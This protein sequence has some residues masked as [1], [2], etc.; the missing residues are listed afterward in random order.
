MATFG[1]VKNKVLV[2]LTE[3]YGK[4]DFSDNLKKYFKPIM[5]STVLKEMYSLYEELE[6]MTFN[7]KE[8][9]QIYV[10]ELSKVL[11]EKH[12]DI[13][14][15]IF[16]LN[17]SLKGVEKTDNNLYEWL[18]TLSSPDKLGN[19]SDKVVAKKN[20]VEHLTRVKISDEL[21][22]NQGVNE[23][24]LNSV[25]VNNFNVSYD[26]TL[27]E[28][29]KTKLKSILSLNPTD[30]SERTKLVYSEINNRLDEL[31]NEDITFEDKATE[32]RKQIQEMDLNRY[33]LYRM[34]DLLE[35]LL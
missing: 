19:I 34:E 31:V 28:E 3:S 18:D 29:E 5:N 33:N 27:S 1:H 2:K 13:S 8:T 22:V 32:V 6:N 17:E 25:L 11:K 12:H 20:L 26:K 24:L 35:S 10:E 9:A 16:D 15:S 21:K 30:L 7:D 4:K 23:N 14:K